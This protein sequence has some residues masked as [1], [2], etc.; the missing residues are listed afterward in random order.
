MLVLD[1]GNALF[2]SRDSAQ[3][4]DARARAELVLSQMDAQGTAAM[5]VGARDLGF[6]VGFLKKQTRQAKL[7]L[8]S[9]NLADAQGKLLFPA[10]LVTT[11]GG[12]KVG[13]VG[14]S[15]AMAKP[16]P[17]GLA[18]PGQP[19]AQVQGLPV[20][21]AVAAEAKRL[22]EKSKVDLVVVLAAV[23]H[24]E[25]LQLADQVEGVDFVVQSHEGR[26]QGIAQRQALATVIP[27][28]ARGR[29]LAKLVLQLEGTGR[30]AD[31]SVQER[32]RQQLRLLEGNLTRAKARLAGTQ[33]PAEKRPL[34]ATIAR[35]EASRAAYQKE[36]AG[37]ATDAGRTHL[38][39]YIQLGSDVP[40]D[41]VVQK[42]VERVEPPGSAA[43]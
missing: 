30:F 35:L 25:A 8:L 38:L 14:V 37:G 6:G 40:A 16:T 18:V 11:V 29:E 5:A 9:A 10:S 41:P 1:A 19:Q 33:D 39:S 15:P 32:T 23:P 12:V 28:G 4:P 43:H 17:V 2:K 31:A 22:R 36:L 13:V 34:E 24:A 27:S 20:Q 7:K 42:W 21:P 3:A 26:G